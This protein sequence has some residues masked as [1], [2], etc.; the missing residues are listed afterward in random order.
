MELT[1]A[2]FGLSC[3]L[4]LALTAAPTSANGLCVQKRDE[5][6]A[7]KEVEAVPHSEGHLTGRKTH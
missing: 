1:W 2:S 4:L 6:W 3:G 5:E 7:H